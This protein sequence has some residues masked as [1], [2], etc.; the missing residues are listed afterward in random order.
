MA[1]V[2]YLSREDVPEPQRHLVDEITAKRSRLSRPFAALLNSAEA[3]SRVASVG[4]STS[5]SKR[6]L[7]P[8]GRELAILATAH[9]NASQHE[10]ARHE[11]LARQA[12]VH[13]ERPS[14]RSKRHGARW[15]GAR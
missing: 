7:D 6:G 14:P 13:D 9:A 11:P 1:R 10:F 2:T 5:A 3:A 15:P 8:Q 4:A 12:G